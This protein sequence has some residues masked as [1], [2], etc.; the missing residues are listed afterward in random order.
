MVCNKILNQ[1]CR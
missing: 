1:C